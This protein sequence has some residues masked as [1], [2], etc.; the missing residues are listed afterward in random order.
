LRRA[1]EGT[2][3]RHVA[4]RRLVH[5]A[6]ELGRDHVLVAVALDRTADEHFVRQ[7]AVEL[8]RVEKVD[9]ELPRAP[10][11]RDGLVLVGRAVEGRHPHAAEPDRRHL[12][13]CQLALLHLPPAFRGG[14]WRCARSPTA[15][16]ARPYVYPTWRERL[17]RRAAPG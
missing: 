16:R 17:A 1:V 8:R 11:R 15:E 3:G 2:D 14:G 10:D 7:R 9:A 4:R 12:H 5:A 6:R 13:V